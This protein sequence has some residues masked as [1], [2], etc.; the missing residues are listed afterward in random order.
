MPISGP[1]SY[2]PT[3][4]AFLDHWAQVNAALPTLQPLLL[5]NP[6]GSAAVI[7]TRAQFATARGLLMTQRDGMEELDFNLSFARASL[8]L[9]RV[10]LHTWMNLFNDRVRGALGGSAYERSLADVPGVE[11]GLEAFS[12]PMKRTKVLWAK[13]NADGPAGITLPMGLQ[14][15]ADVADFGDSLENLATAFDAVTTAETLSTVGLEKRNDLQAPLYEAMKAYRL[16][17]PGRLLRESAL[18]ES[19]PGL[20]AE[21]GRTP[22]PVS[23]SAVWDGAAV[24][25]KLTIGASE[26]P[27]LKEYEVRY[28]VGADYSIDHEHVAGSVPP[29]G[30]LVF[31]TVKGVSTAGAVASYRVYV[32][33]QSGHE[34]GSE[35]AVVARPGP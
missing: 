20:T 7:S 9:L 31:E 24:K 32:I 11:A 6:L 4:Q 14:D 34:A 13:I 17:L 5:P 16:A 29:E 19:M 23:L 28:C 10:K 8:G 22:D 26:D 3:T 30:P 25:A 18:V 12:K 33:L 1:T 2:V 35:T 15:G 27:E 21:G